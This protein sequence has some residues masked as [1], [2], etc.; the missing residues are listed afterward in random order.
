MSS[1]YQS[2]KPQKSKQAGKPKKPRN[3][4]RA[5]E[6][7]NQK[8]KPWNK[9]KAPTQNKPVDKRES[10]YRPKKF[11]APKVVPEM[12]RIREVSPRFIENRKTLVDKFKVIGMNDEHYWTTSSGE[13]IKYETLLRLPFYEDSHKLPENIEKA[14]SKFVV[15]EKQLN[16]DAYFE[17]VMR[18][19]QVGFSSKQQISQQMKEKVAKPKQLQTGS[20]DLYDGNIEWDDIQ[21]PSN[22]PASESPSKQK[23]KVELKQ[24]SE[25]ERVEIMKELEKVEQTTQSKGFYRP[26][27]DPED[28]SP[29]MAS[30]LKSAIGSADMDGQDFRIIS[31]EEIENKLVPGFD[32]GKKGPN[33]SKTTK[34]VYTISPHDETEIEAFFTE[35]DNVASENQ[36]GI[37]KENKDVVL[38]ES[39]EPKVARVEDL[40]LPNVAVQLEELEEVKPEIILEKLKLQMDLSEENLENSELEKIQLN[41]ISAEDLDKM[42]QNLVQNTYDEPTQENDDE[43]QAYLDN[44]ANSPSNYEGKENLLDENTEN[45]T[46]HKS[47]NEYEL[48]Q[49]YLINQINQEEIQKAMMKNANLMNQYQSQPDMSTYSF[50]SHSPEIE[51]N[52]F[53]NMLTNS[54]TSQWFYK[55]P[56]GYVRGPFSCFDMYTWHSQGYFD[57]DLE[58][59]LN[60]Q[61]FF[62]LKDLRALNQGSHSHSMQQKQYANQYYQQV[63]Q[64]VGYMQ[65]YGMMNPEQMSY[66]QMQAYSQQYPYAEGQYGYYGQQQE[67]YP[68]SA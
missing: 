68:P 13:G 12:K 6:Q 10:S 31:I 3:Y 36:L 9:G 19:Y 51:A 16:W 41:V 46:S 30:M 58:L 44:Q 26:F 34:M 48:Q 21:Q 67:Y 8:P 7:I 62:T 54:P 33:A 32:T 57:E 39:K 15:S 56:Q 47:D 45:M 17:A 38:E 63:P 18:N 42:Q 23:Y 65:G 49:Q 25:S 50:Q 1:Q 22:L 11:Y 59:S 24:I 14:G 20:S 60:C 64:N 35:D 4:E 37:A 40:K 55:D 5:G 2:G 43:S 27:C 52:P 29:N 66:Y 53:E 61:H 28:R